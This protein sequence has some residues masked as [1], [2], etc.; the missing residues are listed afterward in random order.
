MKYSSI[1][2]QIPWIEAGVSA[3]VPVSNKKNESQ[4]SSHP[5]SASVTFCHLWKNC[6]FLIEASQT[7]CV[8]GEWRGLT[9]H[10]SREPCPRL[11]AKTPSLQDLPRLQIQLSSINSSLTNSP[12]T[13]WSRCGACYTAVSS[14]LTFSCRWC[15][16][17]SQVSLQPWSGLA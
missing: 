11:S 10:S 12:R 3:K 1:S 15:G 2:N 13:P 16:Q 8:H 4:A 14:A 9:L 5:A 17:I 7:L 6:I